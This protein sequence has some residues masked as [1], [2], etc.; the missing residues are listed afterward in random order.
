VAWTLAEATA[1]T[2]SR[3]SERTASKRSS[4]T[5]PYRTTGSPK[6][7]VLTLPRRLKSMAVRAIEGGDEDGDKRRSTGRANDGVCP[8][9][10]PLSGSERAA[11]RERRAGGGPA[12]CPRPALRKPR[13]A[14]LRRRTC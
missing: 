10:H 14:H 1:P 13:G 5:P 9:F 3:R 8:C 12:T 2:A 7:Q 6:A 11:P 4:S